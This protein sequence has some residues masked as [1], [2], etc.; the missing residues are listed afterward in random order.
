MNN[1]M[2]VEQ[3]LDLVFDAKDLDAAAA[4][5]HGG[6][7]SHNSAVPHD[8]AV[9]SGREAFLGFFRTPAGQALIHSE[10]TVRRV[11]AGGE[12]VAVHSSLTRPDGVTVAIVDIF[13]VL[14]GLVV[15]HWDV[16]QP[17]PATAVNPHGMF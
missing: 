1:R 14:D 4:L 3:L 10:S 9:Q 13:R 7:V 2:I 8:P 17:V 15:E 6:F 12:L 16:V 5:L 11:V